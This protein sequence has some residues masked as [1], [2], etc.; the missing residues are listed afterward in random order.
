MQPGNSKPQK[1]GTN[2]VPHSASHNIRYRPVK[3][4]SHGDLA[5]RIVHPSSVILLRFC[6]SY[7]DHNL[8]EYDAVNFSTCVGRLNEN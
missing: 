8:L 7:E 3:L 5:Y 2:R 6:T 1:C 4:S